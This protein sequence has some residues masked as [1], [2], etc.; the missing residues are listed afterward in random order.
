MKKIIAIL[1]LS[2]VVFVWNGC[3][4]SDSGPVGFSGITAMIGYNSA[5]GGDNQAGYWDSSWVW[6]P[7]SN[8][9][10]S[11]PYGGAVI[12]DQVY[13]TGEIDSA[14]L[15]AVYWK[16]GDTEATVLFERLSGSEYSRVEGL[17]LYGGSL[18]AVGTWDE[19]NGY[20]YH[21]C[22]W[23][24]GEKTT[25]MTNMS[26]GT[27]LAIVD[28]SGS[29]Q[30]YLFGRMVVNSKWTNFYWNNGTVTLLEGGKSAQPLSVFS[31]GSMVYVAGGEGYWTLDTATDV[32][33]WVNVTNAIGVRGVRLIDGDVYATGSYRAAEEPYERACYWKNGEQFKLEPGIDSK[34]NDVAKIDGEIVFAG[35]AHHDDS[36]SYY[37]RACYWK[38]G[39]RTF[40]STNDGSFVWRIVQSR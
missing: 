35:E 17:G 29:D 3:S 23:K 26:L 9:T 12:N 32:Q 22:Y 8:G 36:P 31:A 10:D 40:I 16:A 20:M 33:S 24:D 18:Y 15:K 2:Y 6:H 37:N 1:L 21:A 4:Q 14:T 30:L 39:V 11:Y 25:L 34:G 27:G 19:T 5:D 28:N 7:V 38:N 13:I